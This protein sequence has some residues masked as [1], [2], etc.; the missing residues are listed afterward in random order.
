[1][2]ESQPLTI[3]SQPIDESEDESQ[4]INCFAGMKDQEF[5]PKR[6]PIPLTQDSEDLEVYFTEEGYFGN[7]SYDNDVCWGAK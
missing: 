1:M 6:R 5:R 7:L 3:S 2:P 4:A